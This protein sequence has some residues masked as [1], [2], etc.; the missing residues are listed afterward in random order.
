MLNREWQPC[1][2]YHLSHNTDKYGQK[3][4]TYSCYED[5]REIFIKNYIPYRSNGLEENIPP[6][7]DAEYIGLIKGPID[8][9]CIIEAGCKLYRVIDVIPTVKFNQVFMKITKE[10]PVEE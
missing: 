7:L 2:I 8:T 1:I 10:R 9:S 5:D 6:Y 4:L 3:R